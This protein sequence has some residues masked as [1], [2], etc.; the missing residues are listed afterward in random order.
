M[1]KQ[2]RVRDR[3]YLTALVVYLLIAIVAT[4]QMS[5]LDGSLLLLL[6]MGIKVL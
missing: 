2:L 5:D 6:L 1:D 3:L 4:E